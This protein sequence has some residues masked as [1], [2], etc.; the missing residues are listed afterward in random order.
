MRCDFCHFE[1]INFEIDRPRLLTWLTSRNRNNFSILDKW[2]LP[3][4]LSWSDEV[5]EESD[6]VTVWRHPPCFQDLI[7]A[8]PQFYLKLVNIPAW[9]R[10]M[11]IH[12]ALSHL[13]HLN[14]LQQSSST[15]SIPHTRHVVKKQTFVSISV[16]GCWWLCEVCESDSRYGHHIWSSQVYSQLLSQQQCWIHLF[17]CYQPN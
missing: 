17:Q 15:L 16:S 13:S 3:N 8:A 10:F 1:N 7:S 6:C 5:M 9:A 4:L 14:C 12:P 2:V 11:L